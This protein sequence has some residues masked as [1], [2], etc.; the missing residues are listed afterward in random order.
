[1]WI[2]KSLMGLIV[3]GVWGHLHHLYHWNAEGVTAIPKN[4]PHFDKIIAAEQ[5]S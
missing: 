4:S 3:A 5:V 2:Q 1:M